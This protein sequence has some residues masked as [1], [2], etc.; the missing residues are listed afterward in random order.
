MKVFNDHSS[1][2]PIFLQSNP[3]QAIGFPLYPL[4]TS[5][6]RG[7]EERLVVLN[8][9]KSV[10]SK[11]GIITQRI[12]FLFRSVKFFHMLNGSY[13]FYKW[14]KQPPEVFCKIGVL[15]SFAKFIGKHLCQ[16]LWACNF[17]KKETAAQVFSCEFYEISKNT[18]LTEHLWATASAMIKVP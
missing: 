13:W 7:H 1:C 6:N 5:E 3:F 16:S 8:R 14:Q 12:T 10:S 18:F 15:R 4:E 2:Y 17:I 9:L 11:H